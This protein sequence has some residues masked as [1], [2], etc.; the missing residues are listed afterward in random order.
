MFIKS[1]LNDMIFKNSHQIH[2]NNIFNIILKSIERLNE[3]E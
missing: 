3:T 1:K 2:R